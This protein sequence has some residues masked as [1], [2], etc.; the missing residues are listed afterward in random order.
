MESLLPEYDRHGFVRERSGSSLPGIVPSNTY[1]CADGWVVLGAN[2]DGPFQRLM[3]AIGRADLAGDPRL[4]HDDGRS[5][6]MAEIDDAIAGWAATQSLAHALAVLEQA[7]VPSGPIL[8][9]AEIAKDPHYAARGM[10]ES[11]TLPDGSPLAVPRISP[12][13]SRTPATAETAGPDL[14]AH[15]DEIWRALGLSADELADLRAR[16][17]V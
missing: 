11:V 7:E 17:I 5:R 10:F 6:H 12:L 8:S 16:G 1:R 3:I 14:G 4:A 15:N 2:K 9:I 13:L